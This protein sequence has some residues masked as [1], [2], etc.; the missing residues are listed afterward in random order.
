MLQDS[1]QRYGSVSRL[2]HWAM[3]ALFTWQFL[4]MVLKNMLGRTPLTGFWVGSH[5]SVGTL[6]FLLVLIRLVWAL[7]Q[8]AKRPAHGRDLVGRL[9]AAGHIALYVL[10]IVV[11]SLGILRMFGSDKPISLFGVSLRG[12]GE[13]VLWMTEPANLVHSTLAWLL[14]ALIVGHVAMA[15]VH[16]FAWKDGT[17]RR[18]AG[19]A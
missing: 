19:R 14:L 15:L 4:G 10:M 11:P 12:P 18:M 6:L 17:L 2:L 5:A 16:H 8:K 3:A 13:E 1:S 7:G 9:A